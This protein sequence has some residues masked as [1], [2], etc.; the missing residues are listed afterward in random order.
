M[1]T[2][3]C[4]DLAQSCVMLDTSQRSQ[5]T[6]PNIKPGKRNVKLFIIVPDGMADHR[7]AGLGNL[8]PA[9]YAR[10]PGLDEVVRRGQIGLLKTM[11]SGLPLGSLVG[12]LGIL[13]YHP[14]SYFPLGRSTFEA[15]AL[16]INLSPRDIVFRCNVVGVSHEGDLTDFTAGQISDAD[17]N[18]YL[19]N[20]SLPDMIEIHHDL[21][22]RNVLV[23]R[24]CPLDVERIM[25]YEP[26]ENVG[27]P[28]DSLLPRYDGQP[29]QPFIDMM[30]ASR[31]DERMLWPWGAGRVRTFPAAPF[32]LLTVTALSFLSGMTISLGGRSIIPPGATGYLGSH[33]D[34]KLQAALDNIDQFDVCLIHCNAPDEEAHIRSFKGKVRA[35]EDIDRQVLAPLLRFLDGQPEPYRLIIAP[36]HYTI[37]ETGRHLPDLVPFCVMGHG[38]EPAHSLSAYSEAHITA[39]NPPT[40]ESYQLIPTHYTN[41]Q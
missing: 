33:L 28:I 22:Y 1:E 21:S 38:L 18:A 35:C 30:M 7:H 37:T 27:N 5:H 32:R 23:Y 20:I 31:R 25:L 29:Y 13:G 16:G 19:A 3:A 9:E 26:H 17:A 24:D 8:S 6:L 40:I 4:G 15:H 14:P 12:L 34:A 39:A 2:A 41:A 36:D 10:T 11:Y